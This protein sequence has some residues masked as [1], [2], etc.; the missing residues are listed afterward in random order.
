MRY[1][2]RG[3]FSRFR[4]LGEWFCMDIGVTSLLDEYLNYP[5]GFASVYIVIEQR[6]SQFDVRARSAAISHIAY[7]TCQMVPFA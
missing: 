4:E 5:N 3:E 7:W 6:A 1:I 2:M